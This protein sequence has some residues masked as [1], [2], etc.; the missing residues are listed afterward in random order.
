LAYVPPFFDGIGWIAIA[1]SQTTNG[2]SRTGMEEWRHGSRNRSS[3][4]FSFKAHRKG[5]WIMSWEPP[6]TAPID[7]TPFLGKLSN[8]WCVTMSGS[9]L[10]NSRYRWWRISTDYVSVPYA[11]SH[12]AFPDDTTT[13]FLVGWQELP[14]DESPYSKD[15]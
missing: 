15:D 11:P 3:I 14:T 2:T 12:G 7:G 13:L 1:S 10:K 8:G 6:S 5:A 4:L 9:F